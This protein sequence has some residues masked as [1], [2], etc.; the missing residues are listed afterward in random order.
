MSAPLYPVNLVLAGRPV[1]LVGGG[2]V[3]AAKARGLHQAGA[4]LRVVAPCIRDEVRAVAEQ[5]LERRFDGG[6]D[7][8]SVHFVVAAAPPEVN[9]EVSERAHQR[10]LFVL[11]V[12]QPALASAQSPAVLRRAGVTVAISTAGEAPALSGLLR[13][14]L[15][16]LLPDEAEAARWI[17]VARRARAT[18]LAARTAHAS[19]RPLLLQALNR[20]YPQPEGEPPQGEPAATPPTSPPPKTR[21][22]DAVAAA[23]AAGAAEARP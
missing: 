17:E 2:G 22:T 8:D 15:E 5:V 21:V 10:G 16:A 19:R 9:R 7:L 18:W 23:P 11:A 3:A 14:A 6:R 20:L 4:R 1:L 12:D 13:E